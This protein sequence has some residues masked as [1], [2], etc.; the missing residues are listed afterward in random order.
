M[1][2]NF[3]HNHNSSYTNYRFAWAKNWRP[4]PE[5]CDGQLPLL[6]AMHISEEPGW[7]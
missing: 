4:I 1:D 2:L 3:F 7:E 5:I 6:Q